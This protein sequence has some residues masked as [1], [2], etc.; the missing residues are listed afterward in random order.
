MQR[1]LN[2]LT[3]TRNRGVRQAPFRV[4]MGATMP[5]ILVEV[6][7]ISNPDEEAVAKQP[8]YRNQVVDAMAARGPGVPERSASGLA[9]GAGGAGGGTRQ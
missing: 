6:G 5:A 1:Q 2:Q 8:G 7:F 9:T 3:G 4:L